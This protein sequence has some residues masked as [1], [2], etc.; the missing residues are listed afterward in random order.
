MILNEE[1]GH[2]NTDPNPIGETGTIDLSN[3]TDEITASA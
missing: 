2:D 1:D 3:E